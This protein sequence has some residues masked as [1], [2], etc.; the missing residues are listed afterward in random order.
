M[1]DYYV[2]H[3]IDPRSGAVF[4]VGKGKG[5]R[6]LQH[7][8]DVRAGK[9]I[10]NA[11]KYAVIQSII[12]DGLSVTTIKVAKGISEQS[13]LD[14]EEEHIATLSGLTNIAPRGWARSLDA[15]EKR[16][17]ERESAKNYE[18]AKAN[19]PS[20]KRRM[21]PLLALDAAGVKWQWGRHPVF[22]HVSKVIWD[23]FILAIEAVERRMAAES[24]A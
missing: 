18:W 19:M 10:D 3:L 14:L 13:A 20:L 4:Y 17:S 11:H 8:R 22:A 6:M 23:N 5:G 21:A 24:G 9:K 15:I 1:S 7:E 12:D 2:Y 16:I